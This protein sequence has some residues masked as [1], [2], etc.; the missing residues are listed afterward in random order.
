M[1]EVSVPLV[2]DFAWITYDTYTGWLIVNM[3]AHSTVLIALFITVDEL[4]VM[5]RRVLNALTFTVSR[6]IPL[7]YINL[8]KE[9]PE[10]MA[11]EDLKHSISFV[12]ELVLHNPEFML[13]PPDFLAAAIA[14]CAMTYAAPTLHAKLVSEGAIE[15]MLNVSVYE[16]QE[17]QH[18]IAKIHKLP[19]MAIEQ[20]SK[21]HA[22]LTKY[23]RETCNNVASRFFGVPPP[24][25]L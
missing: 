6:W 17:M 3:L 8:I 7:N 15:F 19:A 22:V 13:N 14:Y 21:Q 24:V 10:I 20:M 23:R 4:R 25:A 1:E 11:N 5:E 16:S 2:S 18:L 12:H 9:I